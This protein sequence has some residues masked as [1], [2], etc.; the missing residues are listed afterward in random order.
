MWFFV[1]REVGEPE[2][3]GTATAKERK[4]RK[5]TR[6]EMGLRMV[7]NSGEERRE[8]EGEERKE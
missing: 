6:S 2:C 8:R 3:K 7:G 5:G 4:E 1:R